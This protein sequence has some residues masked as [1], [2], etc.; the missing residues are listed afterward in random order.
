MMDWIV[1]SPWH[2]AGLPGFIAPQGALEVCQALGASTLP[3]EI[4]CLALPLHRIV[5]S[6]QLRLRHRHRLDECGRALG[7]QQ[8]AHHGIGTRAIAHAIVWRSGQDTRERMYE[9]ELIRKR[10]DIGL[11]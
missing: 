3:R 10:L 2:A 8:S 1:I 11:E 4:D 7:L 6:S 5:E 9:T